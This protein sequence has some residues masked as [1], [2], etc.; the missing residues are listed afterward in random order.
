VRVSRAVP[1]IVPAATTAPTGTAHAWARA[2]GLLL[3]VLADAA[4][5]DPARGHPVA[6]FGRVA[7]ILEGRWYA[8]SR[9]RGAVFVAVCTGLPSVA[10]WAVERRA[11]RRP[12]VQ[13]LTTAIVTWAVL[14]GAGLAAEGEQM[15]ALLEASDLEGA[16][17]RLR[18]LCARDPAGLG[19][20]DLA[21]ASVESLAENASDAVVAPLLWGAVGGVPALVAYRAVNTL[22]AMVG[23]RSA[24]YRR[25]GWAAARLDDAL[26]LVPARVTAL[27]AVVCAPLVRGSSRQAWRELRRDGGAHPSPN[28]GHPE[29][30]AAGAL[31]VRLGGRNVYPG[32]VEDRPTLGGGRAPAPGDVRRAVRLVRSVTAAG[33]VAAVGLALAARARVV[34]P[35]PNAGAGHRR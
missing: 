19:V 11:A 32:H 5:G 35:P 1:P 7:S 25:F 22:D 24:R 15:A 3:G 6:G 4:L 31:G 13:V 10:A 21:R 12:L 2:S 33:T 23:Y 30:A 9:R 20:G 16:R 27:L 26:N 18:N 28:A 34:A 8:D 14:G 17:R 29:A